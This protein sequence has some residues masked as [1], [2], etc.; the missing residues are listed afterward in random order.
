MSPHRARTLL[1]GL[2]LGAAL[3]LAVA[4]PP[5]AAQEGPSSPARYLPPPGLRSKEFTLVRTDGWFH[6]FYLRENEIPGVPTQLSF[7]HAISRDLYTW[8]EQDTILPV[9]PGTFEGTQMWAPSLHRVDGTWFLFYP[10]MRHEPA[11]GILLR[12]SIS[13][14]TSPDLYTWTRREVPLFDNRLFPWAYV[15]TTTGTGSDCRDPFLAWDAIRGEWLLYVATRP[16][17]RPQSMVIGIAGS[18]D[19]EHWSDRGQIPITL[20]DVSFSDVAESPHVFSRDD[21]LLLFLWT[22]DAGQSLTFGRSTDPVTGWNTSRRLRSML[23]YST[24]G[25]WG[26]EMLQDGERWYFGNVHNTWVDFWDATWTAAD[27]FRVTPPDPLQ[28]LAARVEP[29]LAAPGDTVRLEVVAVNA[30][31]RS[32]ALTVTRREGTT[33]TPLDPATFGLPAPLPLAGDTTHVLFVL[34]ALEGST[35]FLLD[36]SLAAGAPVGDTLGYVG[37]AAP[38]LGDGPAPA[39]D[40]PLVRVVQP[41]N[42]VIRF[43]RAATAAGGS[44]SFVV[45]VRD[46]RGRRVWRGEGDGFARALDW[47]TDGRGEGAARVAPGVYFARVRV[48]G[49]AAPARLK[50][51]VL[52]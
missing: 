16:A 32:A 29:D 24:A 37:P 14:A 26:S 35:R 44:G 3:G 27:T 38:E 25:W 10:G 45:E 7:G 8:T 23:G 33:A 4:A 43:V 1:V 47:R 17:S 52:P 46:V 18:S 11:Q 2:F 28:L 34:P 6:V 5:V 42:G 50:V 13:Y 48:A 30:T 22:T 19:L 21:S 40:P 15:D 39:P 12:Q 20:P 9:V 41:R 51:V 31:G 36:F 49:H